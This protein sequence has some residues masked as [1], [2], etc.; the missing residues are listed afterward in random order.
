MSSH[1]CG[2]DRQRHCRCWPFPCDKRTTR[3]AES[4]TTTFPRFLRV[5]KRRHHYHRC[6]Q[7]RRFP[8]PH[9]FLGAVRPLPLR[10]SS[11]WGCFHRSG[12]RSRR[13]KRAMVLKVY[14][15]QRLEI[16]RYVHSRYANQ[17]YVRLRFPHGSIQTEFWTSFSL[18]RIEKTQKK[19]RFR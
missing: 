10:H 17:C 16:K 6:H 8:P 11:C 15:Q 13:R 19:M 14:F 4:P 2:C 18:F 12:S 5:S 1:R 9:K 7:H 3:R